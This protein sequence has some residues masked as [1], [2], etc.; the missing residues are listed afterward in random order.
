LEKF[1]SNSWKN[2]RPVLGEALKS[3]ATGLPAVA[4]G[5]GWVPMLGKTV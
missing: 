3:G 1:F 4:F 5:E 2:P